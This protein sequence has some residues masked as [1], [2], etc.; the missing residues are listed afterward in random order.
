MSCDI[1]TAFE[2]MID[3]D[4]EEMVSTVK[5]IYL[6]TEVSVEK[7][8]IA[9]IFEVDIGSNH[10]AMTLINQ[11]ATV[12]LQI[13]VLGSEICCLGTVVFPLVFCLIDNVIKDEYPWIFYQKFEQLY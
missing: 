7:T 3:L 4:A 9:L 6:D 2:K 11:D 10:T 13:I 8:M 1:K 12:L 5:I